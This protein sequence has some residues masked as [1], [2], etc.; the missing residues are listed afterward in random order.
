MTNIDI[1]QGNK[2]NKLNKKVKKLVKEQDSMKETIKDLE[3]I[4]GDLETLE[5]IDH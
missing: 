4:I 2:L 3:K 5:V 1:G